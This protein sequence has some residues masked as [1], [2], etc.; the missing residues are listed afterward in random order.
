MVSFHSGLNVVQGDANAANSIGKS[1]MLMVVD[2]A[3]GG[4]DLL[5]HNG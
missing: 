4:K 2:F 5:K 1:T 3:F